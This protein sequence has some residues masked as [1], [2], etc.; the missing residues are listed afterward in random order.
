MPPLCWTHLHGTPLAWG[1]VHPSPP[2]LDH[3]SLTRR[4]VLLLG[5]PDLRGRTKWENGGR[6]NLQLLQPHEKRCLPANAA[7]CLHF[8]NPNITEVGQQNPRETVCMGAVVCVCVCVC[9]RAR[10]VGGGGSH[11]SSA[12]LWLL[13]PVVCI[14]LRFEGTTC[15]QW[16][17]WGEVFLAG[18]SV[19]LLTNAASALGALPSI[20]AQAQRHSGFSMV[21]AHRRYPAYST[22]RMH[23]VQGPPPYSCIRCNGMHLS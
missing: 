20:S 16:L 12:N 18:E 19:P 6:F 9:A 15:L 22:G 1:G 14:S 8:Q 10:G 3:L 7:C 23:N 5:Y 11:E 13:L 17:V 21:G 4:A 2:V